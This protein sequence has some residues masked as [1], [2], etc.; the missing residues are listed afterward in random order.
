MSDS[1][2]K[3]VRALEYRISEKRL[4]VVEMSP[5]ISKF[6]IKTKGDKEGQTTTRNKSG[7]NKEN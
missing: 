6:F 2:N 3:K 1:R 5:A 4:Y 7:L